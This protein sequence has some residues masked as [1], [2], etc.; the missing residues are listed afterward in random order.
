MF[1]PPQYFRAM[2]FLAGQSLVS[3]V[4]EPDWLTD[5][6]ESDLRSRDRLCCAPIGQSQD[7]TDTL[8]MFQC[9]SLFC[10]WVSLS[11]LLTIGTWLF[12]ALTNQKSVPCH[13]IG[14]TELL[15]VRGSLWYLR[16]HAIS[17]SI[18]KQRNVF[19]TTCVVKANQPQFNERPTD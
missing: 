8:A 12:D 4:S 10:C 3:E 1:T 13:M 5:Q 18:S 15:L 16:N 6:S 9:N 17:K 7:I 11:L 19:F 14:F 2:R